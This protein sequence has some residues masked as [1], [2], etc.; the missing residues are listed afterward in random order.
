MQLELNN[1][2]ISIEAFQEG[3]EKASENIDSGSNCSFKQFCE[4][5]LDEYFTSGKAQ[6]PLTVL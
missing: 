5:I 3:T 4:E 2:R 1:K 6:I